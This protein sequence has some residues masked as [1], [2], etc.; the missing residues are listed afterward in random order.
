[1]LR[2]ITNC[3]LSLT[4]NTFSCVST[5]C[6]HSQASTSSIDFL[7]PLMKYHIRLHSMALHASSIPE[8]PICAFLY[9]PLVLSQHTCLFLQMLT[10][11]ASLCETAAG[12]TSPYQGH[13][14][15]FSKLTSHSCNPL[16][17]LFPKYRPGGGVSV[18]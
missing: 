8:S 9:V 10:V 3:A 14:E 11:A 18:G 17:A 7:L 16:K 6:Q 13:L 15:P 12:C 5:N 2:F 1:M 4:G